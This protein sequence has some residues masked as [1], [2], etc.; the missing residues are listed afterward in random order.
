MP[1]IGR[2]FADENTR[3]LVIRKHV[4]VYKIQKDNIIITQIH[5]AGEN[6]R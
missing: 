5:R 1:K 3:F 4:I 2:V 6:W